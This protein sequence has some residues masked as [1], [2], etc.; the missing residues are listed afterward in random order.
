MNMQG[1][2]HTEKLG[3]EIITPTQPGSGQD[4]VANLDYIEHAG[5]AFIVDQVKSVDLHLKLTH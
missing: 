4:L 5:E 3:L 2:N 1:I